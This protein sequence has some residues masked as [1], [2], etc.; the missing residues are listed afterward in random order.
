MAPASN[1][2]RS[3]VPLSGITS[4]VR[5]SFASRGAPATRS[6]R[7]PTS[8][9]IA[10]VPSAP[11]LPAERSTSCPMSITRPSCQARPAASRTRT[12]SGRTRRTTAL[13]PNAKRGSMTAWSFATRFASG[14]ISG[15]GVTSRFSNTIS[16][17][18]S[19]PQ[20]SD[21]GSR[22]PATSTL[23]TPWVRIERPTIGN[24]QFIHRSASGPAS[25]IRSTSLPFGTTSSPGPGRSC[26]HGAPRSRPPPKPTS[27]GPR[28]NCP[29][30]RRSGVSP[31]S[32][33]IP[34]RVPVAQVVEVSIDRLRSHAADSFRAAGWSDTGSAARTG[35]SG[36]ASRPPPRTFSSQFSG[37]GTSVVAGSSLAA[38]T[39]VSAPVRPP[40]AT[41]SRTRRT[42]GSTGARRANGRA[43]PPARSRRPPV[44]GRR[45]RESIPQS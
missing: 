35:R 37:R 36:S 20:G 39:G 33:A 9:T 38:T 32:S 19:P 25:T 31:A 10:S 41:P 30:K 1:C 16:P 40:G 21:S 27:N 5:S 12:G 14:A 8:T 2:G 26:T 45:R 3:E 13:S 4:G 23:T 24:I 28:A 22:A 6:P 43:A 18:A 29:S 17:A 15:P 42:S 44:Q 34:S 11:T 7:K